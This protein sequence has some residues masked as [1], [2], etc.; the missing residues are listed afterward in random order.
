MCRR[1]ALLE[2]K[3]LKLTS[4]ALRAQLVAIVTDAA[5]TDSSRVALGVGDELVTEAAVDGHVTRTADQL[6]WCTK[7]RANKNRS[8]GIPLNVPSSMQITTIT[9]ALRR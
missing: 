2:E 8:L 6:H 3:Q 5:A 4:Y 1:Y 9:N 7:H